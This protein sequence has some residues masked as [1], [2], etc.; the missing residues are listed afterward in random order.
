MG[1]FRSIIEEFP[2]E[3]LRGRFDSDCNVNDYSIDLCGAESHRAL[4]EFERVLCL[5][6][7][8]RTGGIRP[9]GRI[10]DVS[11]VGLQKVVSRQQKIR[12]SVNTRDFLK[13]IGWLN[14][15]WRDRSLRALKGRG[16]TPWGHDVRH[17]AMTLAAERGWG[18]KQVAEQLQVEFGISVPYLTVYF[19]LKKGNKS[20]GEYSSK[21]GI[22]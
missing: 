12:F 17:R 8:M 22:D 21:R 11:Y 2:V 1:D 6:L 16:W 10:G 5:K 15:E 3:Y 13:T 18:S 4:M 19:W 9:Y 20:W 14:V 7:G